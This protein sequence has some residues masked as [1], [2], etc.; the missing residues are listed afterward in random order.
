MTLPL[1]PKKIDGKLY[2][3]MQLRE[4]T[5]FPSHLQRVMRQEA[6]E[7][8]DIFLSLWELINCWEII[9]CISSSEYIMQLFVIALVIV[10]KQAHHQTNYLT[11]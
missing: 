3:W 8:R 9:K 10:R 4:E 5:T 1:L 7:V 6:K 2:K 11:Q